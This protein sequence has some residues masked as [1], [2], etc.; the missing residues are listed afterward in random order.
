MTKKIMREFRIDEISV[1]DRPAQKGAKM[2]I[3]KRQDPALDTIAKYYGEAQQGKDFKTLLDENENRKKIWEAREEIYPLI[4]ALTTS[5]NSILAD[6]TVQDKMSRVEQN[7]S[8]FLVALRDK[9]PDVEEEL[10]KFFEDLNAEYLGNVN[11]Q[12]ENNMPDNTKTVEELTATL[13]DVTK[14]LEEMTEKLE[15]AEAARVE[16]ETMAKMSDD[17]RAY[18]AKMSDKDKAD[19]MAMS[20]ADRK[21]KMDGMKKND[22]TVTV[23]GKVIAKSAVGDE[24]FALYK[25]MADAEA[26]IAKAEEKAEMAAFE[27]RAADEYANLPGT[28]A[29]KAAILKAVASLGDEVAGNI[30]TILKA[31]NEANAEAFKTIGKNG[32]ADDNS[33][34]AKLEKRAKEIAKA[35]NISEAKAYVKAL[36]ENPELYGEVE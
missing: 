28:D 25:R 23:E 26:R 34:E 14:S 13:A 22:E 8:D 35:E 4:D 30:E 9:L 32:S 27:K 31:A 10:T 18:I 20:E 17:E 6:E 33:A 11:K 36:E 1:V 5:V 21:K 19:L 29:E 12:R 3:M 7:V 15:K 24:T 2:T 16:A